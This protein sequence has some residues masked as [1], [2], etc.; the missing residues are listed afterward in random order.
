MEADHGGGKS[1]H[2]LDK[3]GVPAKSR[4][5]RMRTFL[6]RYFS[7]LGQKLTGLHGLIPELAR[8]DRELLDAVRGLSMTSPIAQWEFIRAIRHIEENRI[9][10]DIVE[11]GVWRG[12][13][14]VIAGLLRGRL[15]FNRQIWAFDT[16]AGMTK[17][18]TSDFKPAEHLDAGKKFAS[19]KRDGYNEWCLASED[20]VL[21]NF[22]DL[23]GDRDLRTVK[24]PVEETLANPNN[25]PDRIAILRLDT[26]FFES[27]KV[28]LEVLYP[29]LS[30]GGVLII[31]DYGEWA[32]ARKAVDEYFAGQPVWLHYVT[33]TVRLMIKP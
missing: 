31:D 8:E 16:F 4:A 33:H 7:A 32:G 6:A 20:E 26:D 9:E 1:R 27:T 22:G 25:L 5:R 19:L 12:G 23:V 18:S 14:L 2:A 11:C 3:P 17:P 13:N 30:K 29:R 10:G 21:R 24:G 28:E 15:G